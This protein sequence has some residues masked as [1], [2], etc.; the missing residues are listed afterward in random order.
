MNMLSAWKEIGN[1]TFIKLENGTQVNM[2]LEAV[3]CPIK[4]KQTERARG[5]QVQF[6]DYTDKPVTIKGL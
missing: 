6:R 1:E 4:K 3:L 5:I 2:M